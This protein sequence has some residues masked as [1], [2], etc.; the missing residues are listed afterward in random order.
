MQGPGQQLSGW[1]CHGF[2]GLGREAA[3]S[4]RTDQMDGHAAPRAVREGE[5]GW[6]GGREAEERRVEEWESSGGCG[7]YRLG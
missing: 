3:E 7:Q 6:A 4:A 5:L 1:R 2:E